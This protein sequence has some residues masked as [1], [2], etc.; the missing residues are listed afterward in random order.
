M[1]RVGTQRHRG[2]G[3]M[4]RTP[5]FCTSRC[6]CRIYISIF[7]WTIVLFA[8][9]LRVISVWMDLD[10]ILFLTGT[11][12]FLLLFYYYYLL[13]NHLVTMNNLKCIDIYVY[14]HTHTH[15]Y[16]YI[17]SARTAL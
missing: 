4:P 9:L 12:L 11:K 16:I 17:H 15:I 2:E 5:D 7:I 1:I 8:S 10:F 3:V 6:G 14:I 13:F